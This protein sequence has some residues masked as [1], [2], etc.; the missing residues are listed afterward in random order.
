MKRLILATA[1]AWLVLAAGLAQAAEEKITIGFLSWNGPFKG[2]QEW[3]ATGDYLAEQLGRPVTVLPLA[4]NE[5]LPAV[6]AGRVDFFTADPAMFV[7][8][9]QQHGAEAVVTMKNKLIGTEQIGAVIFTAA[10][11]GTVNG[12]TDLKG[13]KFG[14]LRRWSFAG[15]QMAEKEFLDA[16]LDAYTSLST[17]RFFENPQAVAKAV[18]SRQI[19]AGAMP[20]GLLEQMAEE[21]ALR[22]EDVKILEQKFHPDFPYLCSTLLYP[23]FPL[24]RTAN[25][26][27]KLAKQIA[28]ALKTLPPEHPAL[29]D[30]GLSGWVDPLNYAGVEQVLGQLKGGRPDQ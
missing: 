16:G 3:G 28:A 11:N 9:R 4:F 5:V 6:A 18:L 26:D 19:D 27:P 24:A 15:W 22:L 25:A 21:G 10:E 8:A 1:T 2:M 7:A 23:G 14:A 17:L 12:L 13:K 20:T 30:A 29:A